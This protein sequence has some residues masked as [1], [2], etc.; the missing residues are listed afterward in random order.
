[1]EMDASV[2]MSVK[3]KI[4]KVT[5]GND[6]YPI[7]DDAQLI[8][9][10]AAFNNPHRNM[11]IFWNHTLQMEWIEPQSNQL[12]DTKK[13]DHWNDEI[14]MAFGVSKSLTGI[15]THSALGEGVINVK[16]LAKEVNTA[17]G[18]FTEWFQK[19]I[20]LLRQALGVKYE[21]TMEFDRMNFEDESKF[22]AFLLQLYQAGLIDPETA[23]AT[24]K[25]HFPSVVK[26]LKE[27]IEM[28]KKGMFVALPS[29]NNMGPDGMPA[30]GGVARGP[31]GGRPSSQPKKANQQKIGTSQPKKATAKLIGGEGDL[32]TYLVIQANEM[33]QEERAIA[34]ETFRI[35][36][37]WVLTET[38]YN[39]ATGKTV[40]WMTP[41]PSLTTAA[42]F[43]IFEEVQRCMA[44]IDSDTDQEIAKLKAET[45]NSE[46]NYGK[47]G[48]YVT[49]KLSR[50]TK[51]RV[52]VAAIDGMRPEGVPAEEWTE[53]LNSLVKELKDTHNETTTTDHRVV[54]A[55]TLAAQYRLRQSVSGSGK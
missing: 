17:Q 37:E 49:S 55:Y 15:E 34:A 40:N 50:E 6:Q 36:T 4:L 51:E 31:K 14:R 25:F 20:D 46:A 21:V 52:T 3:D 5:V 7:F 48:K 42:S 12:S 13:Y 33:D 16:A 38:E 11:T 1:Y 43:M 41:L 39:K 28:R 53:R 35:P 18:K 22:M 23:L 45:S 10:Q 26:R 19:E 30:G 54:A 32:T 44:Q 24:M 9:M 2:A 27:A 29:A 47:R 8:K